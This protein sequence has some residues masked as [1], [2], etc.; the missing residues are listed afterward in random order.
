MKEEVKSMVKKG[1]PLR[2]GSGS[3]ARNN[4]GRGGC[5]TTQKTGRG[6]GRAS[7]RGRAGK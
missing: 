7:G 5:V 6:S 4:R 1:V 3:G 2:D